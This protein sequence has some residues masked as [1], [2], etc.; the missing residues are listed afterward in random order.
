[1]GVAANKIRRRPRPRFLLW[2]AN[3]SAWTQG[4]IPGVDVAVQE[5]NRGP[6]SLQLKIAINN[7]SNSSFGFGMAFAEG[8]FG[9][10][11]SGVHLIEYWNVADGRVIPA[12][13]SSYLRFNRTHG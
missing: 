11:A 8:G 2:P 3:R 5:L 7:H 1:M 13:Q 6:R 9:E 10:N 12:C 4:E